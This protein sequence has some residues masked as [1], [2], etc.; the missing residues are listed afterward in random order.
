MKFFKEF[1]GF[2]ENRKKQLN[3]IKE[4]ELKNNIHPE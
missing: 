3:E 1:E 4:K 2:K